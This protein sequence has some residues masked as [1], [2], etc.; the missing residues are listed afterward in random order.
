MRYVIFFLQISEVMQ[1]TLYGLV[2]NKKGNGLSVSSSTS[3]AI[4][5]TNICWIEPQYQMRIIWTINLYTNGEIVEWLVHIILWTCCC[6]GVYYKERVNLQLY[7]PLKRMPVYSKQMSQK[8]YKSSRFML[9]LKFWQK[10]N[11]FW[12][13]MTTCLG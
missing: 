13:Y 6:Q 8:L 4:Q 3:S 11:F 7:K 9:R 1:Q 10:K 12:W 2:N 5:G